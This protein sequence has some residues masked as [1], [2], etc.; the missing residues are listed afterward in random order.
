MLE[1]H[2]SP[3][4][5]APRKR[6]RA[7]ESSRSVR[8]GPRGLDEDFAQACRRRRRVRPGAR[9][10]ARAGARCRRRAGGAAAAAAPRP[11]AEPRRDRATAAAAGARRAAPPRTAPTP[12]IGQPDGRM[13]LQ[14]QVTPIGQE[15]AWFHDVHA[16][17]DHHRHLALRAGCCCSG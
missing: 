12:G 6:P 2:R 3:A 9:R 17:A 15:A 1:T 10:R 13:G 5:K 7:P 8:A 4:Y 16:D 14:D 11:A